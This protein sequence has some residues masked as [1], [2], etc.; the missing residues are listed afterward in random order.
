M[1]KKLPLRKTQ[2][3]DVLRLLQRH[4]LDAAGFAWG[5]RLLRQDTAFVGGAA[6]QELVHEPTG[7]FVV[8]DFRQGELADKRVLISPGV[9]DHEE[10]HAVG[11]WTIALVIVNRWAHELRKELDAPDLWA[12]F[13]S[14]RAV[15]ADIAE[16]PAA[17]AVT[18]EERT[19]I[20]EA[21]ESLK[22]DVA[23]Q[24]EMDAVGLR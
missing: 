21:V 13:L 7:Y 1:T 19:G 9:Q 8:F 16:L 17:Q 11:G 14:A 3:N 5:F 6:V 2:K 15:A 22:A 20:L 10:A 4:G 18:R 24:A 12:E 23:R